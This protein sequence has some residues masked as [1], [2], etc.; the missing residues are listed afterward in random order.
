MD[1]ENYNKQKILVYTD[2]SPLGKKCVEWG[3]FFAKKFDKELLLLHVITDNTYHIFDKE[4]ISQDVDN[5]L[6]T[7]SERIENIHKLKIHTYYEQGCTCTIIN[8]VA[9]AHDTFFNII[10]VHGKSDPQF[11]SGQ[12]AVKIIK[13]SRIPFFVLQRNSS[14]PANITPILLPIDIKKEKKEQTGW[15]TYLSKNLKTEIDIF[16]PNV[17]DERLKNNLLFSTKFFD[18]F[19]LRYNKV[20]SSSKYFGFNKSAL[21]FAN[22][23][24]CMFMMAMTTK[25][26]SLMDWIFNPPEVDLISNKKGIPVFIINPKKDLYIP[27]I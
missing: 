21:E 18:E 4:T 22:T 8:S 20:I 26:P 16:I 2:F 11:L 6:K 23:H 17:N 1:T 15:V 5:E 9:E 24:D 27:C 25:D 14:L 3:V 10:G 12:S 13:K 7:I 19:D